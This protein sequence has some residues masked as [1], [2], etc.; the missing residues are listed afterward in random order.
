MPEFCY[1][2]GFLRSPEEKIKICL[3]EGARTGIRT[4]RNVAHLKRSLGRVAW[5]GVAGRFARRQARMWL[6]IS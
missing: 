6:V 3:Q 1:V 4:V 5:G 2:S